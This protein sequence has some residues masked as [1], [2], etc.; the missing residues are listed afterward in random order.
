MNQ[1]NLC[2]KTE[3]KILEQVVDT[4]VVQCRC[5]LVFVTPPPSVHVLQAAYDDEYYRPWAGQQVRRQI[6]N[7]R[8]ESIRES[9]PVPGRLLDI[10]CGTGDFLDLARTCGWDVFGTEF[11]ESACGLVQQKG[12]QVVQGDVW[13]AKLPA[14]SFDVVTCWHVLEH[15]TDPRRVLEESFRVLRP[16]GWLILATPNIHDRLFRIAYTLTRGAPPP[17]YEPE[18]REVHLFFFST[19]TLQ[20]L[21]HMAQFHVVRLGFDRGAATEWGKR[22]V[23]ALAH[24]W[25]RCTGLHWGMALELYAQ[26]PKVGVGKMS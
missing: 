9:C 3:W 18:E 22:M 15:V 20:A 8:M 1:C 11:S 14:A 4:K 26:K 12:I 19:K 25:F 21:A 5:G 17:L 7:T 2:G 6:W 23:D 16:G 10:G 24:W 13:E